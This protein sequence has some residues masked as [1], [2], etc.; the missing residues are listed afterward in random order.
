MV[1][2]NPISWLILVVAALFC[3][4]YLFKAYLNTKPKDFDPCREFVVVESMKT[5]L[6]WGKANAKRR[7]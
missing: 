7:F 6:D 3:A 5:N 4:A 1:N 2:D